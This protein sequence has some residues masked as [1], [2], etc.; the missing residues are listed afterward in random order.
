MWA[1]T[2]GIALATIEPL[3]RPHLEGRAIGRYLAWA[4]VAIWVS[5]FLLYTYVVD[6]FSVKVLNLV[7]AICCGS[8]L[9]GP[10]VY[11]WATGRAWRWLDNRPLHWF[12]VRAYGIYLSH[13]LVIYQLRH[14]TKSLDSVRLSLLIVF[15]LVLGISTLLGTL[16]FRFI[17]S[18]FL[19]RRAPWR[20]A[21]SRAVVEEPATPQPA[22]Q[23]AQV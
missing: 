11:Q 4:F 15:P 7:A 22:L 17:E 21:E 16:S 20:R 14:F 19:E 8:L 6:P 13:V 9:A 3:V 5:T 18:P 12:G 10:L 23:P 2:P 1:F